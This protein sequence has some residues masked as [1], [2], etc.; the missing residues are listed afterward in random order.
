MLYKA[1]LWIRGPAGSFSFRRIRIN[2]KGIT[3]ATVR[4]QQFIPIQYLTSEYSVHSSIFCLNENIIEFICEAIIGLYLCKRCVLIGL[5]LCTRCF[6]IGRERIQPGS[7][8]S[9]ELY[10]FLLLNCLTK[11]FFFFYKS[12]YLNFFVLGRIVLTRH[13]GGLTRHFGGLTRHFGGTVWRLLGCRTK[14]IYGSVEVCCR[15]G[16]EGRTP[17]HDC[18]WTIRDQQYRKLVLSAEKK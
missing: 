7:N 9:R 5:Y 15:G 13:F 8:W 10:K 6:L 3:P 12:G 2:K 11:T 17:V 4:S 18:R 14:D 1:L 16:A